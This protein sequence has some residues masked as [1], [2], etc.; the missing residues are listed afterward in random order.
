[1]DLLIALCHV[2]AWLLLALALVLPRWRRPAAAVLGGVAAL[3]VA[4]AF[5]GDAG[6]TRQLTTVHHYAAYD[7]SATEVSMVPFPTGTFEAAAWQWP[8]PFVGFAVLW[9]AVLLGL[10]DRTLKQSLLLPIAFAW[11]G[12]AT[13]LGM[14]A[15][16]APE[17]VVQPVGVD[18]FLWPAGLA[19]ALVTAQNARSMLRLTI[20]VSFG[21]MLA[22]LPVALFS[23]YASDAQ[24]G[25]CLD[26]S[27]VRDI[28]NP[29]T[30]VPFD[31]RL[32]SGSSEQQ[33]W[34]IW[35]EH[36]IFFP[37]VYLMSLFGIAF[38]AYMFHRHGGGDPALPA[39]PRNA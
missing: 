6:P 23:K 24:L 9:I 3:S 36:V 8:L 34:L 32:P 13:W 15:L 20:T 26:I 25:T 30:Q 1:M 14:Q 2:A 22:R 4:A 19:M 21:I 39:R 7:G 33:F 27:S 10:R 38:G 5:T 18:R 29:M 37:G 35:L 28:V 31:P 12:L 11:T 17:T 16:A